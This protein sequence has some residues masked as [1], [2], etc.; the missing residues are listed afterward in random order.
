MASLLRQY[1]VANV[2]YI[3]DR[4]IICNDQIDYIGWLIPALSTST[5]HFLSLA[6]SSL[7]EAQTIFTYLGIGNF[8]FYS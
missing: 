6:K 8:L 3:D 4:C 1:G 2:L 5:G 7:T